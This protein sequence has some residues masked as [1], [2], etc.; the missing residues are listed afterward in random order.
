MN[1]FGIA[2][3]NVVPD[4]LLTDSSQDL[5]VTDL[6]RQ[7]HSLAHEPD[8]QFSA[9]NLSDFPAYHKKLIHK[10]GKELKAMNCEYLGSF[11]PLGLTEILKQ[12]IAVGLFITEDR[13]CAISVATLKPKRPG[14]RSFLPA[15]IKGD[16]QKISIIE[17]S[18]WFSNGRF[19]NTLQ[20]SATINIEYGGLI[21]IKGM[22]A[23]T[24]VKQQL[25]QHGQLNA[26]FLE[27]FSTAH[28]MLMHSVAD[29]EQASRYEAK[30]KNEY[31][32]SIDY[33]T[34]KELRKLLRTFYDRLSSKVRKQL[35][36][37]Q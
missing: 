31:R 10:I 21:H 3:V 24:S 16:M 13:C 26:K 28:H 11:E 12:R 36:Q 4:A 15:L 18:S 22:A 9:V 23:H 17:I 20:T 33:V 5:A 34:D 14:W 32:R 35:E 27:K 19:I 6:V 1:T 29:V 8:P 30:A 2:M 25:Q 37:Y 7:L